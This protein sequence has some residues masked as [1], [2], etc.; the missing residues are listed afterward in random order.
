[1]IARDLVISREGIAVYT[2]GSFTPELST[3]DYT[4]VVASLAAG[5]TNQP[6]RLTLYVA[7]DLLFCTSFFL[8]AKTRNIAEAVGYQLSMLVPFPEETYLYRYSARREGD[9]QRIWL[10][11]LQEHLVLPLLAALAEGR[12]VLVG[13]FPLH[14]RFVTRAAPKKRW[15][16]LLD[17][18]L[19]KLLVFEGGRLVDRI[20][21]RDVPDGQ[22]VASLSR[23][24]T[25][26]STSATD[27]ALPEAAGRLLNAKP[28]H[29]HF[30]LLPDRFRRPDYLTAA[31]IALVALCLGAALLLGSLK[32]VQ[33]VRF[34][35]FLKNEISAIMPPVQKATALL[36]RQETLQ[37]SISGFTGLGT[38]PDI[39]AF[40]TQLTS[41]LP[42]SAYLDQVQFDKRNGAYQVQGYADD[43]TA[44]T[45]SLQELGEV[46]LKSTSRRQNRTYF[47]LEITT[48]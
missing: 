34:N 5:Q 35:S 30:D 19:A 4:A 46:K 24:E 32:V 18:G 10:Y 47:Q 27:P 28:L 13:L 12:F 22:A 40:L 42:A 26:F 39:V 8:P 17:N 1:M 2:A 21:C 33:M 37:R 20:L 36:E 23:S 25:F 15:S 14:Q 3:A 6:I 16:L 38:N 9:Q 7:E 45:G 44:L 29:K 43:I 31:I 41:V 48:P 11:A